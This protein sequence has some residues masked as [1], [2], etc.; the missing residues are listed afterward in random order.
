MHLMGTD[1]YEHHV[2]AKFGGL[3]MEHHD[4]WA[5][6]KSKINPWDAYDKGPCKDLLGELEK[7]IH[8]R[9]M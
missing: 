5:N 4:G 3:V 8:G 2:G 9:G 6:W 1:E 7:A